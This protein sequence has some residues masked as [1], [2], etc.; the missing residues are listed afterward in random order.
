MTRCIS[1]G[2]F[3]MRM[4][5]KKASSNTYRYPKRQASNAS[6]SLSLFECPC[7]SIITTSYVGNS[8]STKGSLILIKITYPSF[9]CSSKASYIT[10]IR[11]WYSRIST[12][13][14]TPSMRRLRFASIK[15]MACRRLCIDRYRRHRRPTSLLRYF[16][17]LFIIL[18]FQLLDI[19]YPIISHIF[20]IF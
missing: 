20:Y 14:K 16:L 17:H 15:R 6:L 4:C 2:S 18:C 1:T 12:L 10:L 13:F 9:Q 11:L 3:I 5:R 19:H 8:L 7:I